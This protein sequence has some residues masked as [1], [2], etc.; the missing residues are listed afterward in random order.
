M[1]P[2]ISTRPTL[3]RRA[4][5][6][7]S[8]AAGLTAAAGLPTGFVTASGDDRD[9]ARAST[10]VSPLAPPL[11]KPGA[12][13]QQAWFDSV[14]A[15]VMAENWSPPAG[16]RVYA[17]IAVASYEAVWPAMRT[18]YR[19]LGQQLNGLPRLPRVDRASIDWHAAA[20]KAIAVSADALFAA[21]S[22]ASRDRNSATYESQL[23]ARVAAG[24]SAEVLARSEAFGAAIGGAVVAWQ[25]TDGYTEMR[26]MPPYAPPVGPGLWE[27]TP[28]NFRPAIEPYWG[29]L[30]PMALP[31]ADACFPLPIPFPY[32]EDPASEFY[33]QAR[34]VYERSKIIT[35]T[36]R[37]IATFW[38]DNPLV[39]GTPAGHWLQIISQLVDL[40]RMSL[41]Q[42]A[43]TYAIAAVTLADAF[44]STWQAKFVLNL[45]R[46]V[47]YVRRLIDPNWSTIINTPQFPE[48]TSGH[49][50]TSNAVANVLE[51]LLGRNM[52]FVDR[53]PVPRGIPERWFTSIRAAANEAMQS[54]IYG[55]I[56]YPMGIE[57]GAEQGDRVSATVTASVR[58]Q[59]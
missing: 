8:A 29:T 18:R 27:S 4:L 50:V 53:S 51:G 9:R 34:F 39:T 5:L 32:S 35:D 52:T 13:V 47:T 22:S 38:T 1:T 12:P 59:R 20:N 10:R 3:S 46:P 19:S 44:T 11:L 42:A 55:G 41:D 2:H 30:R 58:I 16:A 37:H 57:M 21:A 56:H 25:A 17:I 43:A 7:A 40:R 23:A 36:E 33:A 31:S 6:G 48:Y 15:G 45:V 24:V 54:R 28:P 26:A 49:S 14:Y